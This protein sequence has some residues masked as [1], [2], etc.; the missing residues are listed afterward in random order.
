MIMMMILRNMLWPCGEERGREWVR[1]EE[2]NEKEKDSLRQTDKH[3][4]RDRDT[5]GQTERQRHRAATD[6]KTNRYSHGHETEPQTETGSGIVI[7]RQER[8]THGEN[9]ARSATDN[10]TLHEQEAVIKGCNIL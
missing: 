8:P 9:D 3:T 4:E 2:I 10:I 7:S 1:E 5:R 6:R